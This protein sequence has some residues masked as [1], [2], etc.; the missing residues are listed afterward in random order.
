[1]VNVALGKPRRQ[2]QPRARNFAPKHGSLETQTIVELAFGAADDAGVSAGV[3]PAK[4]QAAACGVHVKTGRRA[5]SLVNDALAHRT[6][7]AIEDAVIKSQLPRDE[8]AFHA[9]KLARIYNIC[10]YTY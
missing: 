6:L 5:R 8:A 7:K 10:I 1:M 3:L 9:Q 2:V 4:Q